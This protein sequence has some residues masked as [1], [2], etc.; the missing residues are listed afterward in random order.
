MSLRP[1]KSANFILEGIYELFAIDE[2]GKNTRDEYELRIEVPKRFPNELPTVF[3]TGRKISRS[4][5][6]HVNHDGSLCLGSP[7]RLKALINKD[8]TL[9]GFT[10][11]CIFPF[12]YAH[13]I[14]N[15]LFGELSHGLDGLI[16]D[17]KEM[18]NVPT[19]R[20]VVQ[21]LTLCSLRRRVANKRKC[22]CGCG[23][24]LGVCAYRE[25]INNFRRI[26]PRSWFSAHIFYLESQV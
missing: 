2:N 15:F 25:K 11:N 23:R 10:S 16:E 3:E 22:P 7:L 19:R 4:P 1:A 14:G 26:A 5:D 8:S 17:Y 6:N 13:S 24:R 20:Q 18:F 12:L 9:V 21:S